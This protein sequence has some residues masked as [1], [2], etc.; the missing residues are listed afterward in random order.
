M[1]CVNEHHTVLF[2]HHSPIRAFEEVK[3]EGKSQR[4][5]GLSAIL[6]NCVK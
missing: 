3:R 4:E 2:L 1:D 5:R 6:K